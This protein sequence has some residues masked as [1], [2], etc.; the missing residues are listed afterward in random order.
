MT[1]LQQVRIYILKLYTF[2]GARI[3]RGHRCHALE[4]N[5]AVSLCVFLWFYLKLQQSLDKDTVM[6]QSKNLDEAT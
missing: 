4:D 2:K 1:G 6:P 5:K 3:E